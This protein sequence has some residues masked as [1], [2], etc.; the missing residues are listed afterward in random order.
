MF[1]K[2]I[3][4]F[5]NHGKWWSEQKAIFYGE[6]SNPSF[7]KYFPTLWFKTSCWVSP[8]T[9]KVLVPFH[10]FHEDSIN[11]LPTLWVR[12]WVGAWTCFNY[13]VKDHTFRNPLWCWILSIELDLYFI[14]TERKPRKE[15]RASNKV[16]L[17]HLCTKSTK[18]WEDCWKNLT[19]LETSIGII[20]TLIEN[21]FKIFPFLPLALP[22][23]EDCLGHFQ[24]SI[25][26]WGKDSFCTLPY[27]IAIQIMNPKFGR[28]G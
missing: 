1:P 6:S 8:V 17:D 9:R 10:Q 24:W 28:G 25:G 11:S 23:I 20:P 18:G 14:L 21:H 2:N 16:I 4:H 22:L 15:K 19:D 7:P 13:E 27:S 3:E 5:W 26:T 12:F